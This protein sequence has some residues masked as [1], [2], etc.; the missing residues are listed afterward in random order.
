[1]SDNTALELARSINVWRFYLECLWLV[2]N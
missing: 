2:K 1:V